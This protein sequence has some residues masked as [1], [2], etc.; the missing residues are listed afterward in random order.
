MKK[1]ALLLLLLFPS[2]LYGQEEARKASNSAVRLDGGPVVSVVDTVTSHPAG[3]LF[4]TGCSCDGSSDWIDIQD[5]MIEAFSASIS[6]VTPAVE[7]TILLFDNSDAG[8]VKLG[9]ISALPFSRQVS[10][11]TPAVGD[12]CSNTNATNVVNYTVPGGTLGT[13]RRIAF[14]AHIRV[15]QNTSSGDGLTTVV[16]YG[17]TTLLSDLAT[18]SQNSSRKSW[19]LTGWVAGWGATMPKRRKCA[20]RL[21]PLMRQ[22]LDTAILVPCQRMGIAAS[23]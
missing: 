12:S 18:V 1:L 10:S 19:I 21:T 9:L 23:I 15:L 2:F 11:V 16:S 22:P 3:K 13:S 14:T 17:G 20:F 4:A 7:D 8:H 6:T 5:C